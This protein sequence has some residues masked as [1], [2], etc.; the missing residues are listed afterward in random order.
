MADE[1]AEAEEDLRR[2]L[3]IYDGAANYRQY[4]DADTLGTEALMYNRVTPDQIQAAFKVAAQVTVGQKDRVDSLFAADDVASPYKVPVDVARFWLSHN[5]TD[6]VVMDPQANENGTVT[7]RA[8]RNAWNTRNAKSTYPNALHAYAPNNGLGLGMLIEYP[9]PEARRLRSI[10]PF[11]APVNFRRLVAGKHIRVCESARNRLWN[12]WLTQDEEDVPVRM[13][14]TYEL[15]KYCMDLTHCMRVVRVAKLPSRGQYLLYDLRERFTTSPYARK[16][17]ITGNPTWVGPGPA[18]DYPGRDSA[19]QVLLAPVITD[20]NWDPEDPGRDILDNVSRNPDKFMK[21]VH[22]TGKDN[23]ATPLEATA[24]AGSNQEARLM[25][26]VFIWD[27]LCAQNYYFQCMSSYYDFEPKYLRY[28]LQRFVPERVLE[29]AMTNTLQDKTLSGLVHDSIGNAIRWYHIVSKVRMA[30]HDFDN[31][32]TGTQF[33]NY[34]RNP[35]QELDAAWNMISI[36]AP[37]S[38]GI[39]RP[40]RSSRQGRPTLRL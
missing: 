21:G 26:N 32:L 7:E 22:M 8:Q 30:T 12:L 28:R 31:S 11:Q 2:W 17:T 9:G 19:W 40:Y 37:R 20:Y 15:R 36:L 3:N 6:P 34:V 10:V 5:D 29:H 33:R 24:A 16:L 39:V 13:I 23:I 14:V 38:A 4:A 25:E 35:D 1:V 27:A 18:M